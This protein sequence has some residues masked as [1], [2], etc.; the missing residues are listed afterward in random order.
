MSPTGRLLSPLTITLICGVW[1][2]A[3]RGVVAR[4]REDEAE[5]GGV[6]AAARGV[7]THVAEDAGLLVEDEAAARIAEGLAESI[8]WDFAAF[9]MSPFPSTYLAKS[10]ALRPSS[11]MTSSTLFAQ[12][13][14]QVSSA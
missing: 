13:Q 8:S 2:A 1:A 5:A 10:S 6:F 4:I 12:H 9:M 11:D 14:M 3:A 7:A